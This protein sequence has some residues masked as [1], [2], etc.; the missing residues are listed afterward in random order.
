M[1]ELAKIC[2]RGNRLTPDRLK[3]RF[4]EEAHSTGKFKL[5]IF[6]RE[7]RCRQCW[8]VWT[9]QFS[10]HRALWCRVRWSTIDLSRKRQ[11]DFIELTKQSLFCTIESEHVRTGTTR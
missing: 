7:A 4:R 1:V 11:H 6:T 9:R 2:W 5:W 10:Q 8:F 3:A